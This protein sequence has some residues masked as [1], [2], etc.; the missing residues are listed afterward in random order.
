MTVEME[1]ASIIG[2]V[3]KERISTNRALGTYLLLVLL[4]N[5][6]LFLYI[7]AVSIDRNYIS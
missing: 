4:L 6:I 5:F 3:L 1:A 7:L 2:S